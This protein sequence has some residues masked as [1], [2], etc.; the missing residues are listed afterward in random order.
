VAKI[1][2]GDRVKVLT[3]KDA[4]KEGRVITIYPDKQKALVEG[5]NRVTRHEKVRP[6]RGRSGQEGGI[7]VKEMPID[8]SNIALMCKTDG[9]TRVGFRIEPDG[10]KIRICKKCEAE[11]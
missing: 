4:G 1:L 2:K 3:G 9:A 8:L 7:I 6:A 5:V 10:S 11:L